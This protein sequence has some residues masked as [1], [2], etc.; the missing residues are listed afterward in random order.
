MKEMRFIFVIIEA[1]N[2]FLGFAAAL[3]DNRFAAIR[4]GVK[5]RSSKPI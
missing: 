3:P 5:E 2:L 1:D 4:L